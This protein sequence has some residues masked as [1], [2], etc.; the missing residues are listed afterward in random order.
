MSIPVICGVIDRRILINYRVDPQALAKLLPRP[1]VPQVVNGSGI[2][3]ICLIRLKHIRPRFIP[4]ALGISSENAAHRIAVEWR[5]DGKLRQGVYI[6]RRDTSSRLN[7]IAGGRLFPGIHYHAR[8]ESVEQEDRYRVTVQSGDG[9]TRLMIDGRITTDWPIGSAFPSMQAASEFF[10]AGS[11][12]Y[13]ATV[14]QG[15]LDGL[16]LHCLDWSMTPLAVDYVESSYF[17]NR[18]LFPLGTIEF[19]SAVLMRGIEHEWHERP[20]IACDCATVAS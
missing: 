12:G 9:A 2:A 15:K 20:S 13:S 11:L 5:Q 10:E 7:T 1:F 3:G 18:Q 17:A 4:R 14:R 19:D 6:P 8:F 16:E